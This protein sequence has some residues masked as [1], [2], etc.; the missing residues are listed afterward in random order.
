MAYDTKYNGNVIYYDPYQTINATNALGRIKNSA[1]EQSDL[2]AQDDQYF[3]NVPE[4]Y[5]CLIP[6]PRYD[7]QKP[8]IDGLVTDAYDAA[9]STLSAVTNAIIDYCNEDGV[10]TAESKAVL[11][12]YLRKKSGPGNDG[13][14][15]NDGGPSTLDDTDDSKL[16]TNNEAVNIRDSEINK[17]IPEGGGNLSADEEIVIS[18]VA[19]AIG[20]GV[21]GGVVG[22][23]IGSGIL[24]PTEQDEL[25]NN[26][27]VSLLG[28]GVSVPSPV[29]SSLEKLSKFGII[30]PAALAV[31]AA[32]GVGGKVFYD[33]K[34]DDEDEE[35]DVDIL[36]L[37]KKSGSNISSSFISGSS[38][39]LKHNLLEVGEVL[40]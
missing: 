37:N 36:E 24:S 6:S 9:I 17:V 31:F 11:D 18:E 14:S 29:A 3:D 20:S 39:A 35:D 4:R 25:L 7:G 26:F 8:Y 19:G 34:R 2:I 27:S 28:A 33:K 40:E 23:A 13:G 38:V 10:F 5:A 30:G 1:L 16:E 22:G 21:T 12:S 15:G 32:T